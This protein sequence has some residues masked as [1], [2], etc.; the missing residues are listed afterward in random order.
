MHCRTTT[1]FH[2]LCLAAWVFLLRSGSWHSCSTVCVC[3]AG[4]RRAAAS[5][6]AA[7]VETTNRESVALFLSRELQSWSRIS[8]PVSSHQS[9]Q[10]K[11]LQ[12]ESHLFVLSHST[13]K[14]VSLCSCS[15]LPHPSLLSSNNTS[16]RGRGLSVSLPSDLS[17]PGRLARASAAFSI[18]PLFFAQSYTRSGRSGARH[19]REGLCQQLHLSP[20][21]C[22]AT[23]ASRWRGQ[24]RGSYTIDVFIW[25]LR[26]GN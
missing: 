1:F 3:R 22:T 24:W 15:P 5:L 11:S 7:S 2:T 9:P 13:P 18:D 23:I 4:E 17:F 16:E 20:T 14:L 26:Q 8:S 12:W 6:Y 21:Q 19:G 10:S 25:G